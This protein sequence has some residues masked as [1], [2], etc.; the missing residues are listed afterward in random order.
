MSF[1]YFCLF[2]IMMLQLK[3]D[4]LV[5]S[6]IIIL[7]AKYIICKYLVFFYHNRINFMHLLRLIKKN[8][9]ILY[10]LDLPTD[11]AKR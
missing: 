10:S 2:F 1:L 9:M 11:D 5:S 7:T 6:I 3:I 4:F 8:I